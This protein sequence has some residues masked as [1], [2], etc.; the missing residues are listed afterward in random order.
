MQETKEPWV[1]SLGGEDSLEE[2]MAAHPSTLAWRIPRTEKPGRLQFT[3]S[4]SRT[5]L[6]M[7]AHNHLQGFPLVS[8]SGKGIFWNNSKFQHSLNILQA[9]KNMCCY[10]Q[11]WGLQTF[12]QGTERKSP[13]LAACC[14]VSMAASQQNN[15]WTLK[16]E[17]HVTFKCYELLKTI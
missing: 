2:D 14:Q 11:F 5:R 10:H 17:F 13:W 16:F 8:S 4:Q 3:G 7:H 9:V 1:W 6:S 12:C 15:L